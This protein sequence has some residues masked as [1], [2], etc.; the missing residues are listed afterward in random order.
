[1]E[2]GSNSV[3]CTCTTAIVLQVIQEFMGHDSS[4]RLVHLKESLKESPITGPLHNSRYELSITIAWDMSYSSTVLIPSG[5]IKSAGR[6]SCGALLRRVLPIREHAKGSTPL[7]LS[8]AKAV[9]P[10]LP[11][12][13]RPI[14]SPSYTTWNSRTWIRIS[15]SSKRL[16]THRLGSETMT[17]NLA[18]ETPTAPQRRT[19][20]VS[21]V[22]QYTRHSSRIKTV[23]STDANTNHAVPI[24]LRP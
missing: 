15:R 1:M 20:V 23:V 14:I 21:G 19:S 6:S 5:Y 9:S 12:T 4:T 3:D 18:S 16:L 13:N 11:T 2:N 17:R 8:D 10:L 24:L 7:N 22:S